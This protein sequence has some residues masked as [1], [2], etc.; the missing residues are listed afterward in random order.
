VT[1]EERARE[2]A[3]TLLTGKPVGMGDGQTRLAPTLSHEL[4]TR[5]LLD[6]ADAEAAAMRERAAGVAMNEARTDE[7]GKAAKAN[8]LIIAAAIRAL[9][10]SD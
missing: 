5:V 10:V 4:L 6:F 2:V 7:N 1:R 9:P 3:Q 8:A